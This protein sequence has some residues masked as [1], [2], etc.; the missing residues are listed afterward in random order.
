M[1]EPPQH[2]PEPAAVDGGSPIPRRNV[3]P[4]REAKP[5][6]SDHDHPPLPL[7]YP[8]LVRTLQAMTG[9]DARVCRECL[10]FH[11]FDLKRS[12]QSLVGDPCT[13][14]FPDGSPATYPLTNLGPSPTVHV[15]RPLIISRVSTGDAP[16][17]RLPDIKP[18]G[19][20]ELASVREAPIRRVSLFVELS[21]AVADDRRVIEYVESTLRSNGLSIGDF[22][23]FDDDRRIFE[24]SRILVSEICGVLRC[25]RRR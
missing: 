6:V 5:F 22:E 25:I 9:Q 8:S 3:V 18:E 12:L 7:S 23:I 1:G 15:L 24:D 13:V 20:P 16:R 4:A 11:N 2:V 21:E 10:I 19:E 14:G 17:S